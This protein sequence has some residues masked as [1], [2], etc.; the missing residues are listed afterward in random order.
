M[1][2]L[3]SDHW[4]RIYQGG[5]EAGQS[6]TGT[7]LFNNSVSGAVFFATTNTTGNTPNPA[8][9]WQ[10]VP[11]NSTYYVLRTK[12]SEP[13]GYLS[14]IYAPLEGTPG[15]TVP[16]MAN[17][18][19][20]LDDSI[21][22]QIEPWGDGTWYLQNAQN[23]SAWHLQQKPNSLMAMSSNITTTPPRNGQRFSFKQLQPIQNASFS[24]VITP[25]GTETASPL[26]ATLATTGSPSASSSPGNTGG[27]STGAK[28]GIGA[29]VGIG[30][31]ILLLILG[32]VLLK[33]RKRA[34]KSISQPEPAYEAVGQSNYFD[35][36]G[37]P[38]KVTPI[39]QIRHAELDSREPQPPELSA[40]RDPAEL[41]AW[42][43]R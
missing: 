32:F 15:R 11:Y 43:D 21:F 3:A 1:A 13:L 39:E 28:A 31:L 41:P 35:T 42:N 14:T 37:K 23:G 4:H 6:L 10:I 27:L 19:I 7:E 38:V 30:A 29:G 33:R 20:V 2:N 34:Q 8:Q 40:H 22:W 24:T 5:N 25:A 36:E 9:L 12:H 16:R 18:S 26:T 17:A